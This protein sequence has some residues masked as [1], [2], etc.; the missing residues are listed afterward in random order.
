MLAA[1]LRQTLFMLLTAAF[2]LPVLAVFASWG[3]IGE[4][5]SLQILRE[6]AQTVLP[7][8]V[9]T[10][11]ILCVA[12]A[13]GVVVVGLSAAVAVTLFKDKDTTK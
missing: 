3:S 5:G 8:Y 6:M 2:M 13:F 9:G 7:D 12:V 10:T 1:Q 11:L 4:A